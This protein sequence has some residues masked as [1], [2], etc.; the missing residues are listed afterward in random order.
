MSLMENRFGFL[1]VF[2]SIVILGIVL[3]AGA[4]FIPWRGVN[5]G[6]VSFLPEPTIT[7]VGE[8][9][10]REKSQVAAFTAGVAVVND[11]KETAVNEVNQKVEAL[12]ESVKSFGIEDEDMKTQNLSVHQDEETYY[13]E[14]RQKR[15]P[16]QWRVSNSITIT[17]RDVDRASDLADLLTRSGATNVY[18]PNFSL[19][20]SEL[21]DEAL[22][23]EAINDAKEKAGLIAASSGGN[24]GRI[25]SVTESSQT[26]RFYSAISEAG[27]GGGA[28]IEPGSTTV[29]KSVT[30]VFELK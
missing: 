15:R 5:W 14:G 27:G 25:L 26:P 6:K 12:I 11:D 24:L 23:E 10:G 21:A 8:A 3:F 17:L 4:F 18:G 22:L 13:E 16:G 29:S 30:V 7:V 20:E 1:Q 2:L 28:P 9:R 19:E